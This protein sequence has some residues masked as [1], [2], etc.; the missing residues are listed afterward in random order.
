[1]K[2]LAD[3]L[4]VKKAQTDHLL[5]ECM[6]PAIADQMRTSHSVP[7]RKPKSTHLANKSDHVA[8]EFTDATCLHCDMPNFSLINSQCQPKEIVQLMSDI[9]HRYDRLIDTHGVRTLHP[10]IANAVVWPRC[11]FSVLQSAVVD[12]QLLRHLWRTQRDG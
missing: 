6:P 7:S 3:E 9:F 2:R 8:E 11:A 12:G 1:M 4:E 10:N 5:F